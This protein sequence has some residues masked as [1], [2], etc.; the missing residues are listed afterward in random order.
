MRIAT[1]NLEGKWGPRQHMLLRTLR[2]DIVLLTEVLDTVAVTGMSLHLT[3]GEMQ[4]GRRWAGIATTQTLTA[5]PD[6]QGATAL[7]EVEGLLVASSILPW[8]TSGADDPWTG[9]DTA[10]RTISAVTAIQRSAPVVWGGDWNHELSGRLYAGS[11]AGRA[12]IRQ[13]LDTLGLAAATATAPHRLP[14]ATSIDHIAVPAFWNV[15]AVDRV[16]GIV[17]G[18]ALS[19]HDAYVITV[20]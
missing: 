18:C 17:D 15:T 5:L 8:R 13:A 11:V 2:A 9:G 6:P 7:A 19:D 3:R 20:E 1:W 12:R 10:A 4:P 14:G 16:S